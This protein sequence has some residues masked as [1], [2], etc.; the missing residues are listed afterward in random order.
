MRIKEEAE[1]VGEDDGIIPLENPKGTLVQSPR[2]VLPWIKSFPFF[3]SAEK[4]TRRSKVRVVVELESGI[5]K[6]L[7]QRKARIAKKK[8]QKA[9]KGLSTEKMDVV[10]EKKNKK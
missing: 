9:A 7:Q 2:F 1:V 5:G 10:L 8:A 4:T 3:R 6:E